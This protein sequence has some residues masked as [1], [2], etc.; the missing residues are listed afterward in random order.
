MD[1]YEVIKNY[2][3]DCSIMNG[4]EKVN[5]DNNLLK[6]IQHDVCGFLN[7]L[8]D[9]NYW[10]KQPV[11]SIKEKIIQSNLKLDNDVFLILMNF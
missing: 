4:D 3:A 7:V 5:L 11:D 8:M 6:L 9:L 1:F 10:N 2:I